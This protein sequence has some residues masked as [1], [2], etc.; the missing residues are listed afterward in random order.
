MARVA[1]IAEEQLQSCQFKLL[2]DKAL[3][4]LGIKRRGPVTSS[5]PSMNTGERWTMSR[6]PRVNIPLGQI[7]RNCGN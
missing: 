5:M 2:R 1:A 4:S 6:L 3:M 7:A